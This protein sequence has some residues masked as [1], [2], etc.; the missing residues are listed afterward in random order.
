MENDM[1]MLK[2]GLLEARRF[3]AFF[4][5]RGLCARLKRPGKK[6]QKTRPGAARCLV[7]FGTNWAVVGLRSEVF[8]DGQ[9][10]CSLMFTCEDEEDA[11]EVS[12]AVLLLL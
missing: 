9:Q 5:L 3:N 6:L 7:R 10:V 1:E 2:E 4:R 8:W 11:Q 12:E